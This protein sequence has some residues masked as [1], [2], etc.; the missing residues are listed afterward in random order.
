MDCC[1]SQRSKGEPE[2]P[3]QLSE[4]LDQT[5]TSSE[6]TKPVSSHHAHSAIENIPLGDPE[7][8]DLF[9]GRDLEG[10]LADCLQSCS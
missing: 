4:T 9:P 6:Q 1:H 10:F 2:L 3:G 7:L 8:T 5:A